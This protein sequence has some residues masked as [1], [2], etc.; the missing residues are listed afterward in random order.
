MAELYQ[1]RIEY[2]RKRVESYELE[3]KLLREIMVIQDQKI[4]K[5]KMNDDTDYH[6]ELDY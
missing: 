2:L 3:V 1:M 5:Y 6:E 4:K